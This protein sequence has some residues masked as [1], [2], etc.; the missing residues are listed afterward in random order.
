MT[1]LPEQSAEVVA[2][3]AVPTL[4][5]ASVVSGAVPSVAMDFFPV[6]LN[7]N[8]SPV[9]IARSMVDRYRPISV[10]S[11]NKRILQ[12]LLCRPHDHLDNAGGDGVQGQARS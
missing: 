4:N 3:H 8:S 1:I 12:H 2:G 5:D 7:A 10:C 11:I 9:L 6:V